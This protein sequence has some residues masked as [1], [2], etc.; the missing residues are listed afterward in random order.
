[1]IENKKMK[2]TLKTK[3]LIHGIPKKSFNELSRT[4]QIRLYLN[5]HS[6]CLTERLLSWVAAYYMNYSYIRM[7]IK[8]LYPEI[9]HKYIM[10]DN[11]VRTPDHYNEQ[12]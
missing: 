7:R 3:D 8:E 10:N 5:D 4:E 2:N 1:M 11:F 9:I 12:K 6:E